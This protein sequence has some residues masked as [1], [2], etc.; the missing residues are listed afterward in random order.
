MH[1][2]FPQLQYYIFRH[3]GTFIISFVVL[4]LFIVWLGLLYKVETEKRQELDT[5]FKETGN[6]ARAFEEHT[7]RTIRGADQAVLFLKYQYE[8]NGRS[9]NIPEYVKNGLFASQPFVLVG[10]IDENGDFAVSS[11]V[12]FVPSNLKD[13]EHFFIHKNVDS[14]QLF[15]SQPVLGR[16]SGKWSI[17]ITRRVN[18]PDGSFGGAVVISLDPFYFTEFYKELDLGKN[19]SV[20]LIGRDGIVRARQSGQNTDIG[21]GR[22]DNVL[23]EH[24]SK[25]PEGN[26]VS[27]STVDGIKRIY[28]YRSMRDYPLAVLVGV[29]EEEYLG[30][31]NQ[32]INGY[33]MA[34]T[35]ITLLILAFTLNMLYVTKRQKVVETALQFT[36]DGLEIQVEERTQELRK[37]NSELEI[38]YKE[39]QNAQSQVIHQ[40]KMASIGQLAA[41]VAHEI[42][43]PL[44]FVTSNFETLQKYVLRLVEVIKA[45][46]SFR[47]D[48]PVLESILLQQKAEEIEV[49]EKQAKLE[50]VLQDMNGIFLETQ[51]GLK[52]VGDIVKALRVFSRVDQQGKL[53]E[54]DLNEGIRN[55]LIVSRNEI[56]FVAEV[57]EELLNIPL[58][59]AIG[60]QINQVLLNIILNAAYAIKEKGMEG[61]GIISIRTYFEDQSVYCL[62]SDN[63]KGMPANIKKDIFN[64][65]F[66]T[67]PVGQ[68]TG[69]GL[70]ISYDIIV[71]KHHGDISVES[72]E[73]EGTTFTLRLPH[74]QQLSQ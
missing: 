66:T 34:T 68:G 31:V 52:R 44:G 27:K 9:I 56:K 11:Q 32:R 53:E 16:S 1:L 65:F 23:L 67:K 46:R 69:L 48:V 42:N 28:S 26:Y 59:S 18:K 57:K 50:Y 2:K 45:L 47:A 63:G 58:V 60:G 51:E 33:Y 19:S 24:L 4:L 54:Y 73:G 61:L 15:I 70:S 14:K 21:Q 39:L 62:I 8:R 35:L 7:L 71:N 40:E 20:T 43:N 72:V 64:P 13:R 12:P 41:G 49:L 29:D 22:R 25:A 6:F 5:A 17:Q 38:A 30:K 55:C 36:L 3:V 10:V 74:K 37:K